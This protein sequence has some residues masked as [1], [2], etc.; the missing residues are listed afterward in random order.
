LL[1]RWRTG[2]PD[3]NLLFPVLYPTFVVKRDPFDFFD[4][5]ME[6]FDVSPG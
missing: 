4:K 6:M 1:G 5:S 2:R 3:D